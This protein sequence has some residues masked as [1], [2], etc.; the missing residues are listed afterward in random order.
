M[1][2]PKSLLMNNVLIMGASGHGSVVLDCLEKQGGYNVI[3]FIDTYKKK[4]R[5]LNGYE[6]LGAESDLPYIIEKFNIKGGVVAIGDNW[7][8]RRVVDRIHRFASDFKFI[9]VIHPDAVVGKD[10]QIGQGT[11][12]MPGS[13]VN[14]NSHVGDHCIINTNTSLG[15][16]GS[17]E[18]YSSLSSGVT[19]GGNCFIGRY[20]AISLGAKIIDNT[21]I[22]EHTVI[23]AGSLVLSNFPAHVV[24]YGAPARVIR[25]RKA[26]EPYL[27][28]YVNDKVSESSI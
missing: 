2:S 3:G 20:T 19:I 23:G 14:A 13:V 26:G 22:Q 11:V 18:N 25:Q 9:T 24:A 16:G 28:G 4:G 27:T 7:V 8:R 21:T 1:N 15:H 6:I 12:L 10:V 17:M 5:R